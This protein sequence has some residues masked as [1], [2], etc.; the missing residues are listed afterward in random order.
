MRCVL[1]SMLHSCQGGVHLLDLGSSRVL[2]LCAR[3]SEVLQ[4]PR[5]A[6]RHLPCP[7]LF[8]RPS[9][10]FLRLFLY[11]FLFL[12]DETKPGPWDPFTDPTREVARVNLR[13]LNR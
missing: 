2:S 6:R 1:L 4:D 7:R 5:N 13:Q 3:I 10:H 11:Q 8:L 12:R 9:F